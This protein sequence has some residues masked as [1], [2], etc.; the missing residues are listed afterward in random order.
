MARFTA[1]HL[2]ALGFEDYI[3]LVHHTV[4]GRKATL[5]VIMRILRIESSYRDTIAPPPGL[6]RIMSRV[7]SSLGGLAG[8]PTGDELADSLL[9]AQGQPSNGRHTHD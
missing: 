2:P 4:G 3:R 5:P 6:P 7:L 1:E 9:R 8:Y